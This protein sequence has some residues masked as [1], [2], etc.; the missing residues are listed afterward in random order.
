M[1]PT[2][3]KK[4]KRIVINKDKCQGCGTCTVLAEKAFELS[5]E[6]FAVVKPE[7]LNSPERE[8][9][10]AVKGCPAGAI[11]IYYD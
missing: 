4:I 10:D 8:I 11:E 3:E 7:A 6:G 2:K 9:L 5:E 1:E